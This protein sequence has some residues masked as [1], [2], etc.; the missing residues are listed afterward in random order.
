MTTHRSVSVKCPYCGHH[1]PVLA[2]LP[3]TGPEVI[4][5]DTEDGP[6]CDRYFVA[7]VSWRPVVEVWE[8]RQAEEVTA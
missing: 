2:T 1:T 6:G 8:M 3:Y 5:C 7:R 4:L